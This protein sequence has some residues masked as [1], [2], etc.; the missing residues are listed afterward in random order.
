MLAAILRYFRAH[1]R[2]CSSFFENFSPSYLMKFCA[3]VFDIIFTICQV[4]FFISFLQCAKKKIDS[5]CP[6]A[7]G[8]MQ[9]ILGIF[10]NISRNL[11][12]SLDILQECLEITAMVTKVKNVLGLPLLWTFLGISVPFYTMFP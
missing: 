2:A 7:R 6:S 8:I 12:Y 5:T 11:K 3:D 4:S 1:F 9:T 10:H